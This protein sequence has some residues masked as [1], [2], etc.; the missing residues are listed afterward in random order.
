MDGEQFIR[1]RG[2]SCV[3]KFIRLSVDVALAI[4]VQNCLFQT[5]VR[6]TRAFYANFSQ[7]FVKKTF[8]WKDS[9]KG[10]KSKQCF[11]GKIA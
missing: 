8:H 11:K 6:A 4:L 7:I 1:F 10:I 2:K 9:F 5:Q 3:F